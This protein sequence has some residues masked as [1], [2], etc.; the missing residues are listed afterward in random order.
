MAVRKLDPAIRRRGVSPAERRCV[1]AGDDTKHA[2][3]SSEHKH[4][5]TVVLRAGWT[6]SVAHDET[7]ALLRSLDKTLGPSA[8]VTSRMHCAVDFERFRAGMSSGG[9]K[10][11]ECENAGGSSEM[12]EC[13]SF[14]LLHFLFGAR[15]R[16]TEMEIRYD[17][18]GKI[19][20]YSVDLYGVRIGV[21]V[22]R[23]MTY[24]RAFT[25]DDAVRLLEKKLFGVVASTKNVSEADRW[26]KQILHIQCQDEGV[27]DTL[28]SVYARDIAEELKSDTTVLVTVVAG[29]EWIFWN[30]DGR[31]GCGAERL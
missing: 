22:T 9:K 8:L 21:S 10:M 18:Q 20:D 2:S 29:K 12:S 7:L 27:A 28:R 11:L 24:R 13:A 3:G 16:A 5:K 17:E 26:R 30:Q 31:E 1:F 19:T 15:L 4:N 6:A 25:H 14:E 23:A